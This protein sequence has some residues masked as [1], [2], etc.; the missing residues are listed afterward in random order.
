MTPVDEVLDS[1]ALVAGVRRT[2]RR[3]VSLCYRLQDGR[4]RLAGLWANLRTILDMPLPVRWSLP[5][6]S[7]A[8][9]THGVTTLVRR[10]V[11]RGAAGPARTFLHCWTEAVPEGAVLRAEGEIDVATA[12]LFANAIAAAFRKDRR[13]VADLSRLRYLDGSGVHVLENAARANGG[14]FVVVGSRSAVRRVFE[15]LDLTGTLPVVETLDAARAY[16]R[17]S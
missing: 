13:V 17:E 1:A 11:L 7:L 16:L 3:T 14:R 10:P 12:P 15:I 2:K 9:G 6:Y 5:V 8:S 4:L